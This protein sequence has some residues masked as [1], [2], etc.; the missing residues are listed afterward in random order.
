MVV[1]DIQATDLQA[2]SRVVKVD[3]HGIIHYRNHPEDIVTIDV[4]VIVVD[5]CRERSRSNRTGVQIES[6]KDLRASMRTAVCT[7]E[8]ALTETHVG[9]VRQRHRGAGYGICSRA[10]ATN[11]RQPDEA[12]E[13]CNL[14]GIADIGQWFGRIEWIVMHKDPIGASRENEVCERGESERY[15]CAPGLNCQG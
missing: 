10:S 15:F 8:S 7:D 6:D 1:E 13:V 4:H 9:L 5:L 12:I 14:R 2:G 3:L 11:M